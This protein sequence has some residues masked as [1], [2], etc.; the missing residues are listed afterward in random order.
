[1]VRNKNVLNM[2]SY[3]QGSCCWYLCN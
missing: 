3:L 2:F 1:M